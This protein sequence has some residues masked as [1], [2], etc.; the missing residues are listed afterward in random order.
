[1]LFFQDGFGVQVWPT[2]PYAQYEGEWH[3]GKMD[4]EGVLNFTN[5]DVYDGEFIRG[6]AHGQGKFIK[7]QEY[8]KMFEIHPYNYEGEWVN[9]K[10]H[11]QGLQKE[12]GSYYKG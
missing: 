6:S 12:L 10:P 5:G 9:F 8:D 2:G 7:N 1:M 3:N 4:G 11:G